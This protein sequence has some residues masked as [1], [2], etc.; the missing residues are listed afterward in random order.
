MAVTA[1]GADDADTRKVRVLLVSGWQTVNIGDVA[2][3]PGT[4]RALTE[5]GG[6]EVVLWPRTLGEREREMLRHRFPEMKILA[7]ARTAGDGV[8]AEVREAFEWADVCVHASGPS[9]VGSEQID[10]WRSWTSKPYGFFG[11]TVDPLT[12]YAD[13]LQRSGRIIRAIDGQLLA[14][15][16]LDRLRRASFIWC[17]DSLTVE[18]LAT[19][20]LT[21]AVAFGPDATVVADIRDDAA[22]DGFMAEMDV[23]PHRF[24]CV[25]PRLRYTPYHQLRR[26][27]RS[28]SEIRR[29]AINQGWVHEDLALLR[30]AVTDWLEHTDDDVVIVPEMSYAVDLA[31]EQLSSWPSEVASRIRLLPR[32]WDLA[33]AASVYR[34]ATA[35]VS[36]ECHS[37]LI[38]MGS[39]TP[40]LYLRQSTDTIKGQ[41]YSDLDASDRIVELDNGTAH[42]ISDALLALRG[43][44]ARARTRDIAQ[45]AGERVADMARSPGLALLDATGMS[46]VAL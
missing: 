2:H 18:F 16:D 41:M 15:A 10:L 7:D 44:T 36:M 32:F 22:A 9:M 28:V 35:V 12:P 20:G 26:D 43:E 30:A 23:R 6:H 5:F 31:A 13:S 1:T 29:D 25:V 4:I 8:S 24:M 45:R 42:G 33:E 38:A 3:T 37:P 34:Y 17:R 11:V 39:A 19:Q 27:G 40:A 21:E 46:R 14:E